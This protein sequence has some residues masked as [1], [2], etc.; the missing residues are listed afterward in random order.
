ML[1][2]FQER[3]KPLYLDLCLIFIYYFKM[4]LSNLTIAEYKLANV[5][6]Q[7]RIALLQKENLQLKK[8]QGDIII[9]QNKLAAENISLLH[10]LAH[11]EK[12]I[13]NYQILAKIPSVPNPTKPKSKK[14]DKVISREKM[15][16]G[17]LR[18][19]SKYMLSNTEE[20]FLISIQKLKVIS[21]KQFDWLDSI[22]KRLK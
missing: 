6:L 21:Q 11:K 12:I 19:K 20:Q 10:K 17:I 8:S 1:E 16:Y 7:K 2:E 3:M 9:Q 13:K 15:I 4:E 5:E 18:N 14:K 22:K